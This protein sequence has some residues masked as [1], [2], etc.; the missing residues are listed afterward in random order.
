[1]YEQGNS[2]ENPVSTTTGSTE[3]SAAAIVIGALLALILIGRG[4]GLSAAGSIGVK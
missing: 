1:M 4:F 2:M 3:Y